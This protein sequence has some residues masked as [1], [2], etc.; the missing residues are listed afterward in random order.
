MSSPLSFLSPVDSVNGGFLSFSPSAETTYSS[1][2]ETT[3]ETPFTE[4]AE[5]DGF[6]DHH[7]NYE[8]NLFRS[9]DS[10]LDEAQSPAKFDWKNMN[11]LYFSG[12]TIPQLCTPPSN[13]DSFLS[14]QSYPSLSPLVPPST[15]EDTR[16]TLDKEVDPFDA[17]FAIVNDERV[18]NAPLLVQTSFAEAARY[19]SRFPAGHLLHPT[20]VRTY[21][22]GDELGSGGYGFVMTAYHRA[23]GHEV[24]VKFIIK[25]K[26]SVH[27]WM[28]DEA[29]G[30]L[31]TEV[32][33][34]SL[35]DHPNIVKCLDL[36]EDRFCFYLVRLH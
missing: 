20:F 4:H 16:N 15:A 30:R 24:A 27:A 9:P 6:P 34:L 13:E 21:D 26:I 11:E 10:Q 28:E 22:L 7:F 3:P 36:F 25:R 14:S 5:R 31:P 32:M 23:K 35:I 17:A 19:S 18:K 1:D 8:Q 29:F 12:P 2:D 33:L